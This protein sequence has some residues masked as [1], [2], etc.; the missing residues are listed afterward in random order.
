[1]TKTTKQ[2]D[3]ILQDRIYY[4][5]QKIEI[6]LKIHKYLPIIPAYISLLKTKYEEYEFEKTPIY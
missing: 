1:M 6:L 2:Y 5:K 3:C 4:L